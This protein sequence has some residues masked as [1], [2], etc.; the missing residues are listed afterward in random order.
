MLFQVQQEA[1][2][3][4]L[5]PFPLLAELQGIDT[6]MVSYDSIVYASFETR[7]ARYCDNLM[8]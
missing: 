4:P 3:M 8:L 1:D 7:V 5:L 2:L 6:R